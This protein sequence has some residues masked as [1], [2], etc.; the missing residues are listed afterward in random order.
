MSG[1]PLLMLRQ[2]LLAPSPLRGQLQLTRHASVIRE[3]CPQL[4][5]IHM[6]SLV[7]SGP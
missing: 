1:Q 4:V 3:Q 7:I 5:R 6:T 2:R